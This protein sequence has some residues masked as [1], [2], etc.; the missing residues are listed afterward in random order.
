MDINLNAENFGK[1]LDTI[2]NITKTAANVTN[3]EKKKSEKHQYKEG[4]TTNQQH[5][6]T[7]EVKVGDP[8][9]ASVKPVIIKEKPETHIHKHFP[10]NRALTKDECDLEG[11]RIQLEY[12]DRTAERNFKREMELRAQ[13]ERKEREAYEREERRKKE[14]ERR[15]QRKI[16]NAVAGAVG[17]GFLGFLGYCLYSDSRDRGN[18]VHRLPA[19]VT[20]KAEGNVE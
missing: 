11:V 13:E 9:G 17:I 8:S 4:D 14:E 20:I 2:T 5:Q 18:S 10:D 3:P 12:E 16:R 1:A 7:V 19:S 15:K 6:Q